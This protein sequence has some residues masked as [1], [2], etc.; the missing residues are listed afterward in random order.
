MIAI[1]N[2]YARY[3]FNAPKRMFTSLAGVARNGHFSKYYDVRQT[4]IAGARGRI[5]HSP[6]LTIRI[7]GR[8]R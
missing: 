1:G 3:S 2:F 4:L 5:S 8:F 7:V 6:C